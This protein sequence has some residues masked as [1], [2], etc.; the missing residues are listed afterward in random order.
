VRPCFVF[1]QSVLLFVVSTL[2]TGGVDEG[3]D[4]GGGGGGGRRRRGGGDAFADG[5]GGGGGGALDGENEE[6]RHSAGDR[7]IMVRA[8]EQIL[9]GA[10]ASGGDSTVT[11]SYLQVWLRTVV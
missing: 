4:G 6:Q 7:G 10:A 2:T 11:V 8:L 3:G 5:T 1:V 9:E